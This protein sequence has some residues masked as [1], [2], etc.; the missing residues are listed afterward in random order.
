[1]NLNTQIEIQEQVL[2]KV[3]EL[4][5]PWMQKPSKAIPIPI[6]IENSLPTSAWL[7]FSVNDGVIDITLIPRTREQ[8]EDVISIAPQEKKMIRF[9]DRNMEET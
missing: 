9:D 8:P 3:A 4:L 2:N 6:R 7:K 1:M 5:E